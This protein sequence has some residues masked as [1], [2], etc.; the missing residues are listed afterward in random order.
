MLDKLRGT[1][2][3]VTLRVPTRVD[4]FSFT[5]F[6]DR[7]ESSLKRKVPLILDLS[8]TRFLSFPAIK[9]LEAIAS[10]KGEVGT[11]IVLYG[12]SEKLKQQIRVFASLNG[13]QFVSTY[14]WKD[15]VTTSQIGE[16]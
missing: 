15:L 12:A 4:S 3:F 1:D 2:Q 10:E 13:M 9:F 16:A 8:T 14:E 11:G 7:V 5:D 6:Q